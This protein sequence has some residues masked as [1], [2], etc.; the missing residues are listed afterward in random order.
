MKR[1]LT[2]LLF[3][4]LGCSLAV[5][6]PVKN[7]DQAIDLV[8]KSIIKNKLTMLKT[9]CLSFSYGGNDIYYEIEVRENHN[10]IC[11]GDPETSPKLFTYTVNKNTGRLKT[12][13]IATPCYI[14]KLGNQLHYC[15]GEKG[16]YLVPIDP[17]SP[18]IIYDPPR[19]K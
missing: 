7:I 5:A 19:N 4:L 17:V 9:E 8:E 16:E 15:K 6:K 13:A 11:G 18:I 10:E 1:I 12:D 3:S 2:A 14:N